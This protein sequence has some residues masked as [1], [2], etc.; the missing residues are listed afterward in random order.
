MNSRWVL[1]SKSL[2]IHRKH[3]VESTTTVFYPRL[4]NKLIGKDE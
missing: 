2:A 3:C 1:K 4:T